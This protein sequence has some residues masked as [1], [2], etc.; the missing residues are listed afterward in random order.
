MCENCCVCRAGRFAV[1]DMRQTVAVGVIKAV[2]KKA[3]TGGKV[4][5]S[6]QKAQKAKWILCLTA[7]SRVP[8]IKTE[9]AQLDL[10]GRLYSIVRDCL[11]IPMHRK[12][13]RRKKKQTNYKVF[14][15]QTILDI[16]NIPL[17][18]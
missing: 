14:D 4:T 16:G 7:N 15:L 3:P 5:K 11:I 17:M 10:I 13:I 12:S 9:V 18:F 8:S 6:A 2:E 1:R